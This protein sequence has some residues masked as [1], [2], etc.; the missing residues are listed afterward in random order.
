MTFCLFSYPFDGQG[1]ILAH[2]YYPYDFENYGGD[3]HFD[4]SEDWKFRPEDD[5]SGLS[6]SNSFVLR[7]KD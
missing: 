2:A 3:I 5:Y 6:H 4:E 1:G 7:K